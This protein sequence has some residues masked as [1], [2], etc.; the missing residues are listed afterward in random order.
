[1]GKGS[2]KKIYF[3]EKLTSDKKQSAP[4]SAVWEIGPINA[5]LSAPNPKIE[6]GKSASDNDNDNYW[7]FKDFT[8]TSD[9]LLYVLSTDG[10]VPADG[11]K[12]KIYEWSTKDTDRDERKLEGLQTN[13]KVK[14]TTYLVRTGPKYRKKIK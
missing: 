14:K 12:W 1:M 13:G 2:N 7:E 6:Y 3:S 11:K 9:P 8:A 5:R 10:K 4:T